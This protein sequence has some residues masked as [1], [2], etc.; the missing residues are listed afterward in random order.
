MRSS[1]VTITC[2]KFLCHDSYVFNEI[3]I[4]VNKKSWRDKVR[5]TL[6]RQS[7][8]LIRSAKQKSVFNYIL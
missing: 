6:S 8:N 2:D 3:K 1:L 7:Y 5:A 4:L